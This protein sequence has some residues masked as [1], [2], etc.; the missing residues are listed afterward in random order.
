[1]AYRVPGFFKIDVKFGEKEDGN[2]RRQGEEQ[3]AMD[4]ENATSY[5]KILGLG[6]GFPIPISSKQCYV[7]TSLQTSCYYLESRVVSTE[8]P[9]ILNR[10]KSIDCFLLG[11]NLWV[12][13]EHTFS[14]AVLNSSQLRRTFTS[15]TTLRTA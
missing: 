9:L 4:G 12:S 5:G 1:M 7:H 2:R 13:E 3:E 10:T 15:V 11:N 8:F 14:G 6:R